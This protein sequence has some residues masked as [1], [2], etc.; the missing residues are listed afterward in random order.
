MTK[1]IWLIAGIT[2]MFF[3]HPPAVSQAEVDLRIGIG[4]R[5]RHRPVFVIDRR[6]EFIYLE[7]RGFSVSVGGPY[8]IVYY[9]DRYYLQ[10]DGSWYVSRDYRRDW[11]PVMDYELPYRIRKYRRDIWRFRDS[12]YR[13]HDRRYWDDTNRRYD[14][15]Y[16]DG[17]GRRDGFAP[18]DGDVP[19]DGDGRRDGR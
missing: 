1:K 15:Y 13:R 9:G 12:E 8:D 18:R 16:R 4:E 11:R 19:R 2:G 6:P 10:R 3:A 7:E 5:E 14:R 17:D